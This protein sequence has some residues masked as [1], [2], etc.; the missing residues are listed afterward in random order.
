MIIDPL[1]KVKELSKSNNKGT[2]SAFIPL[3]GTQ[4][5]FPAPYGIVS[6]SSVNL[7]FQ[8]TDPLSDVRK[9][10]IEIDT[11]ATFNSAYLRKQIVDGKILANYQVN[12]L[13]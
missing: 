6:A 1:S 2:L 13:A 4:N 10:H 3:N 12:L 11:S 7:L 9:F 8:I 5:L